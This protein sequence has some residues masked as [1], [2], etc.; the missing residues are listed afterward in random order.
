MQRRGNFI[1][2]VIREGKHDLWLIGCQREGIEQLVKRQEKQER[3][4][5]EGT[6]NQPKP[7]IG[8]EEEELKKESDDPMQGARERL[9]VGLGVTECTQK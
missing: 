8:Y 1:G 7:K 5:Y 9:D 3:N 4:E 2:K 6:K